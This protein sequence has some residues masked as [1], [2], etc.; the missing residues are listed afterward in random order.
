MWGLSG[1]STTGRIQMSLPTRRRT[2][3]SQNIRRFL[4][5][6]LMGAAMNSVTQKAVI[7]TVCILLAHRPDCCAPVEHPSSDDE[8]GLASAMSIAPIR[9]TLHPDARALAC[10]SRI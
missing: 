10:A 5:L 2:Y 9:E 4:G 8:L 1:D 7:P 3:P 6:V